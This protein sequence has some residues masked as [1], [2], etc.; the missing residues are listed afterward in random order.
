[1]GLIVL[2]TR[3]REDIC[4]FDQF[5]YRYAYPTFDANRLRP[6]RCFEAAALHRLW[7]KLGLSSTY[8]TGYRRAVAPA[9]RPTIPQRRGP[10]HRQSWTPGS[11]PCCRLAAALNVMDAHSLRP[12]ATCPRCSRVGPIDAHGPARTT[13][14]VPQPATEAG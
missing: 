14:D 1:M 2:R 7:R 4:S 13:A 8:T 3:P 5:E 12:G 6:A 9:R 10:R 11:P